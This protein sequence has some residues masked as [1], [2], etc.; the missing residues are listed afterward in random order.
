L[1]AY[2]TE[3][4][5]NQI[6]PVFIP[7]TELTAMRYKLH[8]KIRFHPAKQIRMRSKVTAWKTKEKEMKERVMTET[9]RYNERV[10]LQ[11]T[12]G[13]VISIGKAV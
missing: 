7:T 9:E 4:T 3:C 12:D 13:V 10:A 8:S 2:K 5:V 1:I 6:N 11:I